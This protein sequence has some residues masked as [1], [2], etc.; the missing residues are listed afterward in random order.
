MLTA[1]RI[2]KRKFATTAFSGVGARVYGGRWNSPGTPMVYTSGSLALAVLEWRVHLAQWPAPSMVFLQL[3]FD[4]SLVWAPARLPAG[5]DRTLA[6]RAAALLGDRWIRSQ[7]SVMMRVPSAV[8]SREFNYL[9]NP[10]H[11]EFH[12]LGI[13]KP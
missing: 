11:P 10:A 13:G 4:E 1:F 2:V 9:L 7:R 3:T 8:V 5:W 12:K 6:P